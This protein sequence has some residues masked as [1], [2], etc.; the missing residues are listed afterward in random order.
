M[1]SCPR[2]TPRTSRSKSRATRSPSR[3]SGSWSART[4]ATATT[5]SSAPTARSAAPSR[6]PIRWTWS[7][8]PRSRKTA[9]CGSSCP[10]RRRPSRGRSRSASRRRTRSRRP[11]AS[12]NQS[13]PSRSETAGA[14]RSG[15][16]FQGA[17][18][19][20]PAR[21]V[22]TGAPAGKPAHRRSKRAVRGILLR[23]RAGRVH[24]AGSVE[25]DAPLDD[26]GCGREI[27]P[28]LGRGLQLDAL[29]RGGVALVVAEADQGADFHDGL[30]LGALADDELIGGDD[31]S[32]E[33][34]VDPDGAFEDELAFKLAALAEQRVQLGAARGGGKRSHVRGS[35]AGHLSGGSVLYHCRFGPLLEGSSASNKQRGS[36]I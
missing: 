14:Q 1:S 9:C 23:G 8:S 26:D 3:A 5:G 4:S 27:A 24:L 6:F 33:L 20:P 16:A 19:A 36:F 2:W 30:H 21:K 11:A 18:G 25:E 34:P 22:R 13:F 15:F 10:R 12:S 7:T 17:F 29:R 28:H 35:G 31:L 32:R